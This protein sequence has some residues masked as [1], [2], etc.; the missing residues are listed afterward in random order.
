MNKIKKSLSILVLILVL[1][2]QVVPVKVF[3]QDVPSTPPPPPSIPTIPNEPTPP[4]YQNTTPIIPT[5]PIIPTVPPMPTSLPRPTSIPPIPT[6]TPAPSL[7][8]TATPIPS[9]A[10]PSTTP[11]PSPSVNNSSTEII[12]TPTPTGGNST[13]GLVQNGQSGDAVVNTGDANTSGTVVAQGNTNISAD[14]SVVN[15]NS[16]GS[17]VVNSGNGANSQ[18]TGTVNI[19]NTGTTVQDNT[20]TLQNNLDLSSQTGSNSASNNT[21]GNSVVKTGDANVSGTAISAVNTNLSGVTVSEFNIADNHTG[22]FVLNF[23]AN[24]ISGCSNVAGSTAQNSDNGSN[25][26]NS[27]AVNQSTDAG[28][29]QN[30]DATVGNL[31]V[32]Q[33]DTGSNSASGNTNGNSSITTGDANVSAN[34]ITFAN[35]NLDGEIVYG[36]VNIYGNLVGDIVLPADQLNGSSSPATS[37]ANSGNGVN[38]NNTA[39]D[40]SNSNVLTNQTNNAMIGNTLAMNTNSGSNESTGNTGGNSTIKSGDTSSTAQV[41]NVA[42][43]NV[44]NG[45]MWIVLVNNAG[46]WGG[47]IYGAPAGTNFAGSDGAMFT[48]NAA[49]EIS[50]TNSGNGADSSNVGSVTSVSNQT[51]NQTNTADVQNN[52]QLTANTGSNSANDNTGGNST[53]QTGDAKIVA[54]LVNFVNNNVTGGGKLVVT[55]VN[56]FGKWLGDFVGPNQTKVADNVHSQ[57]NI[58]G[59]ALPQSVSPEANSSTSSPNPTSIPQ[60]TAIPSPAPHYLVSSTIPDLPLRT[61]SESPA[62]VAGFMTE[63]NPDTSSI[64]GKVTPTRKVV[65]INLAWLLLILP[66]VG[67]LLAIKA[68]RILPV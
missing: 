55:V 50:V 23:A 24:C 20:A 59:S 39:S 17:Q 47:K 1:F 37:V 61:T 31:L 30:N 3:A 60:P 9:E 12:P 32:L 21:G 15:P 33:A 48:I 51:T 7:N 2:A 53:I 29:F 25:S 46:Q 54:N 16:T 66:P 44:S 8:P 58:G 62:Q 45:N 64:L 22:D 57:D 36:V 27:S 28:T 43:S 13:G 42:N 11:S 14:S 41:L 34:A 10:L 4:P 52:L 65:K 19:I 68:K 38:S 18:N 49:G 5:P 40:I 63:V 26:Q 6:S 67:I 56:V 35:N